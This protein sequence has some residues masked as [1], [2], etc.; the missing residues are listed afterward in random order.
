MGRL[1][2]LQAICILSCL[3]WAASSATEVLGQ[4]QPDYVAKRD[5]AEL[6][7]GMFSLGTLG[8]LG[9]LGASKA[10]YAS[11]PKEAV[12]NVDRS[13]YYY[14]EDP[15]TSYAQRVNDF[16][17][18]VYGQFASTLGRI[19]SRARKVTGVVSNTL[20]RTGLK[21]VDAMRAGARSIRRMTSAAD[22]SLR[23]IARTTSRGLRRISASMKNRVGASNPI[24][25]MGSVGTNVGTAAIRGLYKVSKAYITGLNRAGKT[26]V[27]GLRKVGNT[28]ARGM[29][30]VGHV[31][32]GLAGA[33]RRGVARMGTAASRVSLSSVAADGVS[34]LGQIA[35]D[36]AATIGGLATKVADVPKRLTSV[37]K[38]KK[39]RD[40][41]LQAMCYVSTRFVRDHPNDVRRRRRSSNIP[42]LPS[43]NLQ[44][45][46]CEEFKCEVVSLGRKAYELVSKGFPPSTK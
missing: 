20:R 43:N 37:A 29:S 44:R 17:N 19:G 40:C 13:G 11:K 28:Y 1:T 6:T 33:Y 5:N 38:D 46:D 26:A 24:E 39:M 31:A 2:A 12:D 10:I 14:Y 15:T 34:R 25:R 4:K 16:E 45:E 23:G 18:R 35:S 8:L 21:G 30:R 27:N 41:L 36:G 42:E 7:N 32:S 3:Q 9:L 22:R